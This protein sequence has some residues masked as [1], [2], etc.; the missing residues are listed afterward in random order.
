MDT[1]KRRVALYFVSFFLFRF[2]L[3]AD[4][5]TGQTIG[6]RQTN[7]ASN[8]STVASSVTPDLVDPWGIA[9]LSG[10]PFFLADNKVGLVTAHDANGLGA[11]PGSFTVP[12][13]AATGFDTPTGIVADQNSFFGNS[14]LVKPFLLVTEEERFSPGGRTLEAIFPARNADGQ[15]PCEECSLQRRGDSGFF[16]NCTGPGG[17]GFPWRIHRHFPSRIRT[18]G[19]SR[20][21]YGSESHVGICAF[22][23][24]SDWEQV[25]V[26]YALQDAA[27]TTR[28]L[29]RETASST[30]S[31]WMAISS[32]DSQPAEL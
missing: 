14:S 25:F 11:L 32:G 6:Y 16:I 19:A 29:A 31:I 10:Q 8:L 9:F 13:S 5:V 24:S 17:H 4:N 28:S 7:L 18:S 12:S 27:N 21:V 2:L 23:H 26:A 1:V 30:F 20:F 15:S 22:R 3:V